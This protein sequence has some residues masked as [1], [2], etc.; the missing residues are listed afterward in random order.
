MS[1]K[2]GRPLRRGESVHHRNGVRS[3]NRTENLELWA[4]N[5]RIVRSVATHLARRLAEL[6]R[7]ELAE[8]FRSAS[9]AT[10]CRLHASLS[11]VVSE[12]LDAG[13]AAGPQ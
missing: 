2:L 4:G 1:R 9:P 7:A 11:L 8:L 6:D 13:Q 10:L 12:R 5:Q 3:D